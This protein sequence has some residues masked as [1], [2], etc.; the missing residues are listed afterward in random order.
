MAF[1]RAASRD[2]EVRLGVH[3]II[4]S[5]YY[6]WR[7]D[8]P[9]VD[10]SAS[11]FDSVATWVRQRG[12]LSAT[13][14]ELRGGDDDTPIEIDEEPLLCR[15]VA[16]SSGDFLFAM[17]QVLGE[18]KNAVS[19]LSFDA[20]VDRDLPQ[21][22]DVGSNRL[23]GVSRYFWALP[24]AGAVCTIRM[25]APGT[26]ARQFSRWLRD[27]LQYWDLGVDRVSG[28]YDQVTV[29]TPNDDSEEEQVRLYARFEYEEAADVVGLRRALSASRSVKAVHFR[30][31]MEPSQARHQ[32]GAPF[33]AFASLVPSSAFGQRRV[34]A[35]IVMREPTPNGLEREVV[36]SL[37]ERWRRER[38]EFDL[39]FEFDR[40][41]VLWMNR[42]RPLKQT[43]PLAFRGATEEQVDLA[44]L[45]RILQ[46]R[47]RSQVVRA[48][49][50]AAEAEENDG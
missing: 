41:Q 31:W 12:R 2:V 8:E 35:R 16:E 39:G 34:T 36:D 22:V 14:T 9:V 47:F 48:V 23:A 5:G 11:L 28:P 13:R 17:Y 40:G 42:P 10:T 30:G 50:A 45:L 43:I 18:G 27:Y 25:S 32:L 15:A 24:E 49:A 7:G 4:K 3:Q 19:S 21:P 33:G 26:S 44:G 46:D 29:L 20:R 38:S 37:Q 6:T 1:R